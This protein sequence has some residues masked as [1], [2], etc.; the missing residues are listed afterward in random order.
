M[1]RFRKLRACLPGR[2]LP[3]MALPR[4]YRIRVMR[5]H[6]KLLESAGVDEWESTQRVRLDCPADYWY[7]KVRYGRVPWFRFVVWSINGVVGCFLAAIAITEA[8]RLCDILL[9]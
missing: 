4:V 1:R 6:L 7:S 8:M 2:R 3:E 9:N 5:L